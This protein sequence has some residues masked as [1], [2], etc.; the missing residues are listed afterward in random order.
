MSEQLALEQALRALLPAE[1]SVAAVA[2]DD[3]KAQADDAEIAALGN[4]VDKRRAEF[5][6][7]RYA[8]RL[9]LGG[10][11]LPQ[12]AILIGE[13]RQPLPP[14]GAVLSI[15]HDD[16]HAIAM[17]ASE[18]QCLGLGVDLTDADSLQENLVKSVCGESDLMNLQPGESIEQRAKLVFCLKEALFK[19]I[20]PQ[21]G[22]WMDFS[23]SALSIDFMSASYQAQIFAAD[24]SALPLRGQWF[25]RFTRLGNRWIAVAGM[26]KQ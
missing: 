26:R 21:V 15:T 12:T 10:R 6:A 7:G 16:S 14:A 8:A 22:D 17:A 13:H 25:G 9:A 23:Q 3:A 5:V 2:V 18:L 20:F 19:A 1:V 24:G 4:V 11:D